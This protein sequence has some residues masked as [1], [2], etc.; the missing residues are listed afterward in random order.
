MSK[1]SNTVKQL[2]SLRGAA[3]AP[4]SSS[5]EVR[6]ASLLDQL[7]GSSSI[8]SSKS[9]LLT[10]ATGTFFSLNSP[11]ALQTVWRWSD[12]SV[13]DAAILREAGLKS[14]S[15][16]GLAKVI[17]NLAVLN[18]AFVESGVQRDLPEKSRRSVFVAEP[19]TSITSKSLKLSSVI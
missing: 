17:N 1:L 2:I 5:E 8:S 3:L 14:V 11:S 16:I 7:H 18:Q 19:L 12:G 6:L 15:F 9:T 10:L 4:S 13:K